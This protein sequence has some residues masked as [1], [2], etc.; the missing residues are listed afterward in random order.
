MGVG[1]RVVRDGPQ[2]SSEAVG[3]VANMRTLRV[4]RDTRRPYTA[5]SRGS[6]LAILGAHAK[7]RVALA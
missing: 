3:P 4:L 5:N 1:C 7:Q 6:V 2:L